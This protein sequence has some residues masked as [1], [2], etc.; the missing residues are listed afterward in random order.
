MWPHTCIKGIEPP[1]EQIGRQ[2]EDEGE[3]WGRAPLETPTCY[4][5]MIVKKEKVRDGSEDTTCP[6]GES[7]VSLFQ[8]RQQSLF[9]R[10]LTFLALFRMKYSYLYL[11]RMK[12]FIHEN[13]LIYN[14][15][16]L[17]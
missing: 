8:L 15:L 11:F 1:V 12:L 17:F 6:R 2:R 13:D 9:D 5:L 14:V 7:S 3:E 10:N 16:G 4:P